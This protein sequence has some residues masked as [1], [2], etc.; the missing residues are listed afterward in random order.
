MENNM[1][2]ERRPDKRNLALD[3]TGISAEGFW[4]LVG[5]D[6]YFLSY[7]N[8][9]GFRNASE[10]ELSDIR[11]MENQH[12]FWDKLDIDLTLDMI[13]NPGEYPSVSEKL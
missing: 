1:E 5:E 6:Q 9:P 4:L 12:F 8:F 10:Q 11:I 7:D 2:K 13:K 3:I